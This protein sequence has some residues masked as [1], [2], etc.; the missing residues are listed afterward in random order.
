MDN[1][2]IENSPLNNNEKFLQMSWDNLADNV[3]VEE[4][5]EEVDDIHSCQS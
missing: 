2:S 4:D 1:D 3:E 5:L